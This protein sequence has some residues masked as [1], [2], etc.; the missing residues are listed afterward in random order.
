M[1]FKSDIAGIPCMIE[2][3]RYVPEV[4]TIGGWGSRPED[5]SP[6]AD[7]EVEWIVLDRR[8]RRAEWLE[9]KLTPAERDRIDSEAIRESEHQ[10]E[11]D[12]S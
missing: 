8:G 6:G 5:Y 1:I 10:A 2:V 7:A 11:I 3:T 12:R 9:R 4:P